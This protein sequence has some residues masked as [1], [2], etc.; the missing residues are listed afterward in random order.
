MRIL[1]KSGI[2]EVDKAEIIETE[3]RDVTIHTVKFKLRNDS[4]T[5]IEKI[6]D[7]NMHTLLQLGYIDIS[8]R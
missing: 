4:N 3:A 6:T 7:N 5:I 2:Y 8:W 1:T